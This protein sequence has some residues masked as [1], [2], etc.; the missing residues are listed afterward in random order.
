MGL[1][2]HRRSL[3]PFVWLIGSC[4]ITLVIL[5]IIASR[6]LNSQ[7]MSFSDLTW[8]FESGQSQEEP[9]SVP[10]MLGQSYER[11][12]NRVESGEFNFKLRVASQD[13]NDTV[14]EGNIITQQPDAGTD[15]LPGETVTIT[16]SKGAT[17]RTLPD[18]TGTSFA[19][20]QGTLVQNG[21][22]PVKEEQFSDEVELGY[23]IGYKDHEAGDAL[24]YG[25]AVTVIVSA[26]P[27][28]QE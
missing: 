15:I 24:E 7:G 4:A 8:I 20:L 27:E 11:W 1:P 12:K 25:T 21:F 2:R 5:L 28:E 19:E 26:G 16:V 10:N 6:W 22:S 17:T 23:V 3:P 18:F 14:D 9:I 13:F